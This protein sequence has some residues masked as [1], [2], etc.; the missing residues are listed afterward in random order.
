MTQT[1][2]YNRKMGSIV[3]TFSLVAPILTPLVC[4]KMSSRYR[5]G[6]LIL[7]RR[8]TR[9][10]SE[11]EDRGK[12]RYGW[13]VTRPSDKLLDRLTIRC[14]VPSRWNNIFSLSVRT[15]EVIMIYPLQNFCNLFRFWNIE[16]QTTL[17]IGHLVLKLGL[18]NNVTS[19][20]DCI[21][22]TASI[23]NPNE[24]SQNLA[25]YVRNIYIKM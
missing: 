7:F 15:F 11:S 20:V 17:A 14:K 8:I 4:I 21:K 6:V 23:L 12:T 18:F 25:I 24:I 13:F 22:R 3:G 10:R 9:L 1:T 19:R 5:K 16:E 2:E